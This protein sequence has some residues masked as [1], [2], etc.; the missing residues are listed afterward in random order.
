VLDRRDQDV[1]DIVR[2]N[3]AGQQLRQRKIEEQGQLWMQ[4]VRDEAYLE[5]RTGP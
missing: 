3:R 5:L 4:R 1:T 2:R